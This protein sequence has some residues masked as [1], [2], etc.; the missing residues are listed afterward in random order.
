M[1]K[2]PSPRVC[3]CFFSSKKLHRFVP[4]TAHG[5]ESPHVNRVHV[6]GQNNCAFP[7]LGTKS[8]ESESHFVHIAIFL[9]APATVMSSNKEIVFRILDR[10]RYV[11]T[12]TLPC[13]F[14]H[15]SHDTICLCQDKSGLKVT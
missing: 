8:T 2:C 11:V 7:P 10:R 15:C 12:L 5:V 9:R 1:K 14:D 13:Q 4:T 6:A 3:M